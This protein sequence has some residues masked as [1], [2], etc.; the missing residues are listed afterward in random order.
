MDK[1]KKILMF[2]TLLISVV[3]FAQTNTYYLYTS[4]YN[5]AP[6]FNEVNNELI[7]SGKNKDMASFFS[8]Y[9]LTGFYQAFPEI[10]DQKI[11]KVF[12]LET[13]SNDLANDLLLKFPAI[14][15]SY[16]DITNNLVESL[17]DY[18]PNDYGITSPVANTGAAV[19]RRELDYLNAPEAWGE[20]TGNSNILIGI[21]DT[22]IDNSLPDLVNKTSYIGYNASGSHGTNVASIAA[23]QGDNSDGSVGICYDCDL[24]GASSGIGSTSNLAY[25]KVYLL[26]K[27]GARVINMSWCSACYVTDLNVGYNQVEQDVIN[28]IIDTFGT[29]F[30]AAAG[31]RSSYSSAQYYHDWNNDGQPDTAFGTLYVYPAA[32]KNVI[33]VGTVYYRN[34]NFDSNSFVTVTPLGPLYSNIHDSVARDVIVNDINN[35]EGVFFN[36]YALVGQHTLNEDV[37]ILATGRDIF[38]Y[39]SYGNKTGSLYGSGTSYSAP[40]VSGTIGL[41]IENNDCLHPFDIETI[42]KLTTKDIE[43]DLTSDDIQPLSLNH[44]FYGNIGAGK[45]EIGKSVKFV[46]E[47]SDSN[48]NAVI[49]DHIFHRYSYTLDNILNKLTIDNSRFV[50]ASSASF[51]AKNSIELLPGTLLEP[52]IGSTVELNIDSSITACVPNFNRQ[53]DENSKEKYDEVES[54]LFLVVPTVID[55]ITNVSKNEKFGDKMDS[56]VVYNLLGIEVNSYRNINDYNIEINL[57]NLKSGIYLV[58]VLSKRGELLHVQKIIKK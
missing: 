18:Y 15:L 1:V 33:S 16:N 8:K 35:P 23:A 43:H 4:D 57:N 52:G 53:V 41:M 7:Y 20:N 30:V 36:G 5:L 49:K 26:A 47:M 44:N 38:Q 45:L 10:P 51:T 56:I 40:F 55:N 28:Y 21:S 13:S 12:I 6:T 42:L 14:F 25:S 2:L 39:Y 32:Y 54:S 58:K 22:G 3:T 34:P 29:V 11:L 24:I 50:E 31:N 17:V 9:T 19:D 46:K 48:G 27:S 37:D